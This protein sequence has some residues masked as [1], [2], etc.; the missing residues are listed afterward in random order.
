[1]GRA[2]ASWEQEAAEHRVT[3][4]KSRRRG[5]GGGYDTAARE[6]AVEILRAG[7]SEG[8]SLATIARALGVH[9]ISLSNWASKVRDETFAAVVVAKP[10][11]KLTLVSP[12]GWRLEGLDVAS[13]RALLHGSR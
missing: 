7:R 12:T 4:T 1:M 9:A 6:R 3:L 2:S 11:A 8:A 13:V 10:A 5:R